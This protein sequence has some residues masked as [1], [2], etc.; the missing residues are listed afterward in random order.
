MRYVE[1]YNNSK[2]LIMQLSII[3]INRNN[4]SGLKHTLESVKAQSYNDFEYIIIDGAST[5]GSV[6]LIVQECERWDRCVWISEPDAGIYNAMN[7]GIR[8]AHGEY[9][10]FLNSGDYLVAEDVIERVFAQ[11][12]ESDL[13]CAR[14]RVSENGN[15]VWTSPLVPEKIT[16]ATLYWNGLMHQSTFIRR[17]LLLD[18]GLYDESFRWL[19]D[20][21]FWY[22]AII[23]HDASTQ[24]IDVL[25]SDYNHE[26]ESSTLQKNPKFKDEAHWAFAQPVLRN[27]MPLFEEWRSDKAIAN[28]Y[29][30]ISNH[31]TLRLLLKLLGKVIKK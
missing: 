28:E 15:V 9:L 5:D 2:E 26:G 17:Q 25:T 23:Y 20:I 3:T 8:M 29:R 22:D 1:R 21:K 18:L 12:T 14:C 16:L 6:E 4:S 31:K 13:L 24:P 7:K 19:A 30:W 10:L 27:V 11:K